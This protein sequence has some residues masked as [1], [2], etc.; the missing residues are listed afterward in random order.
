MNVDL[1]C[2]LKIIANTTACCYFL[3]YL[4]GRE[5]FYVENHRSIL[6]CRKPTLDVM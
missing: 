5:P 2:D 6:L 3:N 1:D 4:Y